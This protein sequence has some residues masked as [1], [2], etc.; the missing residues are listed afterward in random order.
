[1][2]LLPEDVNG[3]AYWRDVYTQPYPFWEAALMQIAKQHGLPGE[4]WVRAR[5]G[6]NVVFVGEQTVVKLGPPCWPGEMAR[7]AAALLF[8]AGRLPV[9]TPSLVARGTIN[10]WD[11][12][13]QERLPGTNLWEL[14]ND[15]G[16][17]ERTAL[18]EQHGTI[19]A[20][21]HTLPIADAPQAL[22]FDWD[23]L[24]A[25]QRSRWREAMERTELDPMLVAQTGPYLETVEAE[26]R[27]H[28]DPVLLHGDLTHF[29]LLVEQKSGH[30][31]ITALIDWGDAKIGPRSH[32]LI[33]PGVHMYRGD[34]E[35]LRHWYRGYGLTTL[36]DEHLVMARALLYYPDD[37]ATL[38]PAVPG[39]TACR[40]WTAIARCF[41]H[42]SR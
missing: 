29:N 36:L 7:E 31:R 14:W 37:F 11:Y 9:A 40:T 22:H 17:A 2:P 33:S 41:W 3:D 25:M 34:R 21:L 39:A 12:L 6:R 20:A 42:L 13:A 15:L 38:I 5:L 35:A 4:R 27:V 18:A 16:T 23:G 26:L 28:A 19:M 10:G 24:L 1:M 32:E 30:W 8:V